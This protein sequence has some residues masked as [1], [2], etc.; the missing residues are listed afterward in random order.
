MN[1]LSNDLRDELLRNGPIRDVS[2]V[3]DPKD[4]FGRHF[5]PSCYIRYCSNGEEQDRNWLVYSKELDRVLCFWC[6]LFGT[7]SKMNRLANEELIRNEK[8]HWK[9]VLLRIVYVTRYLA[10]QNL[11]FHGKNERINVENNGNYL[12][13]VEMIAE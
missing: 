5:S 7:S 6:K 11:A 3:N 12:S 9:D 1:N 4:T 13:L 2:I 10:E 8:R